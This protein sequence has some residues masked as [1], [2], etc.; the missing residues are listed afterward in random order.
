MTRIIWSE[1]GTRFFEAGL[2]QGVLYPV[3]QDGVAWNGL[4]SINESSDGGELEALHYDGVKYADIV[5]AEDFVADLQAFGAP[6]EFDA[7]DGRKQLAPGLFVTHQPRRTFGLSYR[8]LIGNDLVGPEHGYK[9]HL[10]YNCTAAPANRSNT[11]ISN[12]TNPE[13]TSWQIA[14]V[15]PPATTYRPS[16]HVVL[17]STVIAANKLADIEEILYG[18]SSTSGAPRLPTIDELVALAA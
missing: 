11:T 7:C 4:I 18:N 13:V 9:L 8:T 2:D 1:P 16:A 3:G 12:V 5:S 17:D 15:P 10:V 6:R 14:T